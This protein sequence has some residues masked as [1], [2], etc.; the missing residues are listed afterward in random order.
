VS[1]TNQSQGQRDEHAI[2]Q[3]VIEAGFVEVK[4]VKGQ[5]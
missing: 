1:Y 5:V 3:G 4:S 2:V